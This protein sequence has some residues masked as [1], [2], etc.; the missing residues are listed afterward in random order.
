MFVLKPME[1]NGNSLESMV[2]TVIENP[3]KLMTV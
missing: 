1:S 3:V 2:E